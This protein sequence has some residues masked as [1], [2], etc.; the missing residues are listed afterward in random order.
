MLQGINDMVSF[1]IQVL[2]Y[3]FLTNSTAS[4]PF[5]GI[6]A[7]NRSGCVTSLLLSLSFVQVQ[8]HKTTLP[9]RETPPPT[10]EESA[11]S[12]VPPPRPPAGAGGAGG[13]EGGRPTKV[14]KTKWESTSSTGVDGESKRPP[15]NPAGPWIAKMRKRRVMGT[16]MQPARN[17]HI[18]LPEHCR[19]LEARLLAGVKGGPRGSPKQQTFWRFVN[20]GERV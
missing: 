13:G 16:V 8:E 4:F 3:C 10:D 1:D 17:N 14:R 9:P 6:S 20:T 11:V 5:R 18:D 15:R 19:L 7:A 12:W 2:H